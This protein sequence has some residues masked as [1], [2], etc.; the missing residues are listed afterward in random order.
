MTTLFQKK[1]EDEEN[2]FFKELFPLSKKILS[3]GKKGLRNCFQAGSVEKLTENGAQEW[4]RI[5]L[6]LYS[7]ASDMFFEELKGCLEENISPSIPHLSN[8]ILGIEKC[9]YKHRLLI[10]KRRF[11][12]ST[13]LK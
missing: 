3:L 12:N 13:L 8:L 9:L 7:T 1:Y 2:T 10:T 4:A 11:S 6:A 5:H